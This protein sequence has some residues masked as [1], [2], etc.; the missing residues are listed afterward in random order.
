[1]RDSITG[2][3]NGEAIRNIARMRAPDQSPERKRV[4][5]L[6]K[7]P[8]RE[9]PALTLGALISPAETVMRPGIPGPEPA[10]AG[11]GPAWRGLYALFFCQARVRR[12]AGLVY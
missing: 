12:Q 4:G 10:A 1:M 9:D 3:P 5:P 11:S 2:A 8:A 7:Q 6:H